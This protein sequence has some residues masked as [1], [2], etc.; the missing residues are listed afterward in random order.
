MSTTRD[1][2][3]AH[4]ELVTAAKEHLDSLREGLC[5]ELKM[6]ILKERVID[7]V[8]NGFIEENGGAKYIVS[9]RDYML[10]LQADVDTSIVQ[11]VCKSKLLQKTLRGYYTMLGV[12]EEE[13][14]SK[15]KQYIRSNVDY[16]LEEAKEGSWTY[17][18]IKTL[19]G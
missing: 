19:T 3:A 4:A 8:H 12:E 13:A 7:L 15:I 5:L 6:L 14:L 11:V 17:G 2:D 16:Y 9:Q 18:F 1:D 10:R